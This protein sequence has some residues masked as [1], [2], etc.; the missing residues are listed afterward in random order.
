MVEGSKPF[1]P[2]NR[3]HRVTIEVIDP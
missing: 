2:Q 3:I 1:D